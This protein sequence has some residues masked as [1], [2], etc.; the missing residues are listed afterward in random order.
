MDGGWWTGSI[1]FTACPITVTLHLTPAAYPGLTQVT[2]GKARTHQVGRGPPRDATQHLG[3][4]PRI[5]RG[6][7]RT[8]R[9]GPDLM[10][11]RLTRS[12]AS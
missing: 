7:L 12:R 5:S 11:A 6:A 2:P 10:I 3:T 1:S 4:C 8:S 9:G